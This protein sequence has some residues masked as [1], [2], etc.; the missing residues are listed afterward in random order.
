[1]W[2]FKISDVQIIF[3]PVLIHLFQ[4][5]FSFQPHNFQIPCKKGNYKKYFVAIILL[6]LQKQ[7]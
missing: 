3:L 1:M 6:T 7:Y 2:V 4:I 5:Y